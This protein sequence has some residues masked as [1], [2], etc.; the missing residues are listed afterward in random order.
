MITFQRP[1]IRPV[2]YGFFFESMHGMGPLSLF[3]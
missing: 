2:Q 3:W 1:S